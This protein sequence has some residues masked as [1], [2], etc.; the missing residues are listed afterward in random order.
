MMKLARAAAL[1][2]LMT[3][4]ACSED[5]QQVV[6]DYSCLSDGRCDCLTTAACDKGGTCL[7]GGC[8]YGAL[9]DT[10]SPTTGADTDSQKDGDDDDDAAIEPGG[11][12][13]PCGEN[14]ECD[15]EKCLLGPDGTGVCTKTCLEDCPSGWDCK[16]LNEGT[17]QLTFY[18]FPSVD[19]LCEPCA[20]DAGCTGDSNLC[21]DIGDAP[22]CGADCSTKPCPGGYTCQDVTSVDGVEGKQC[23]PDSG[24]CQCTAGTVGIKIVCT[25]DNDFGSCPG[26]RTCLDGGSLTACDAKTPQ[27]ET[28]DELDNDCDGFTD[29]DIVA[30]ECERANDHGTCKGV[31]VCTPNVGDVCNAPEPAAE[32]CDNLDNDCDG[33]TDEDFKND[34]GAYDKLT[35]CGLCGNS[36]EGVF[37][38]VATVMCDAEKDPPACAVETCAPGFGKLADDLCGKLVSQLCQPC[39]NDESC[40]AP[41]DKCLQL[42]DADPQTFCAR[43]CGPDNVYAEDCPAGYTCKALTVDGAELQQCVPINNSCDCQEFNAGQQKPCASTNDAGSCFG[44]AICD[45]ALGWTSC[46]AQTPLEETCNGLD[47]NCDGLVDEGLSG[48]PCDATNDFGT[49]A[50]SLVCK[51][52]QGVSCT[53]PEAAAEICDGLDNDCDGEIDEPY[54]VN[55]FGPGGQLAA[56]IYSLDNAH[57]GGCGVT[58]D[59]AS[60]VAS[61]QCQADG[62]QVACKVLECEPGFYA[63]GGAACLPLPTAGLCLP[64]SEDSDCVGPADQC[65]SYDDGTFCG[66]DC[67]PD[68]IY[69][70]TCPAGYACSADGQCRRESNACSCDLDG[71]VTPCEVTNDFGTCGGLSACVTT[72]PDAGWQPCDASPA[73]ETCDGLDNDCDGLIDSN[74][75]SLETAGLALYPDCQNVSAACSGKWACVETFAGYEWSCSAP[76]PIDE[77]CN[78]LDDDC[79]GDVDE[80]FKVGDAFSSVSHCGQCGLDC[81]AALANLSPA[82]G[83]VACEASAGGFSCVP[84]A[85]ADGYV[86]F[87]TE[88]PAV[89][90]QLKASNCQP[91]TD[92][93]ECG[94]AGDKCVSVGVDDGTYCAQQCGADAPYAGCDGQTGVQGCCPAGFLCTDK[95]AG[96]PLCAPVTDSCQCSGDNTGLIRSCT[97]TAGAQ[98]CFGVQTCGP[99]G[100]G[101][102]KWGACDTS[103]N[104]EICDT[105]DNDCDGT[106]DEGFVTDGKYQLQDHCGSCGKNCDLVYNA[107]HHATAKCDGA[108]SGGPQCVIDTCQ[109]G[110]LPAGNPCVDDGD[111]PGGSCQPGLFHCTSGASK[112]FQFKDLDGQPGNGCECPV[113]TSLVLDWPEIYADYPTA[114]RNYIDRDCDGVDGDVQSAIFVS[115]A[116]PAGGSG[117]MVAPMNSIQ[118]AVDAWIGTVHS[119][120]IVATGN[121]DETVTLKPG[122]KLHGGYGTDFKDRDIVLL[123]STIAGGLVAQ[124]VSGAATLVTGFTILGKDATSAGGASVAVKVVGS[125]ADLQIVGNRIVG[126]QGGPGLSGSIGAIGTNGGNGGDGLTSAECVNGVTCSGGGCNQKTCAGHGQSGGASGANG[127][128]GTAKG[129]PGMESDGNETPQTADNPPAG[130]AYQ[131]GGV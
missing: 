22:H 66:R 48:E 89:C 100:G 16:G 75:D 99:D 61:V 45:P 123:P 51:G 44:M 19:R 114:G 6:L 90:L 85:C 95:G 80:D 49:C 56:L 28:C 106:V 102:F 36:C 58:C 59:A 119:A 55:I 81:A 91:C 126:G 103:A 76:T 27:L 101:A 104:V 41:G 26:L 109:S 15:S 74:D 127:A 78:S 14:S 128:C 32:L 53:A 130:C 11:F 120:I 88:A 12:L 71:K 37:A 46:S 86:P 79:D 17:D 43:D 82:A 60:P 5:P 20:S 2:G 92:D 47:D 57:C 83:S 1:F 70:E 94:L 84:K 30:A 116:A 24:F 105:V 69:G 4:L 52:P 67:S 13:W 117:A 124:N 131:T 18:C 73:Q 62:E 108:A 42:N 21:L 110:S 29:E 129:C 115:A 107:S 23:T 7:N 113:A 34:A 39:T 63:F 87:P 68:S 77:L 38:N 3:L 93:A 33:A 112:T 96:T 65:L 9:T 25:D 10:V 121:Y 72:G 54:A 31:M 125:T 40:V 35:D 8:I 97:E 64:C 111:C 98:S 50:G 122:V 118:A